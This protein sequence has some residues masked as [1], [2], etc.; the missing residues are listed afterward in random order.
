MVAIDAD[1]IVYQIGF[2]DTDERKF[3][4]VRKH[5]DDKIKEILTNTKAESYLG[6][7]SGGNSFRVKLTKEMT[8]SC[9]DNSRVI[10]KPLVK[11]YKISR[12]D[13]P[14]PFFFNEIRKYMVEEWG[15]H[16]VKEIEADDAMAMCAS[17][18]PNCI[19]SSKD[20]DMKQIATMHYHLVEKTFNR[21]DKD[22]AHYNLYR[23]VIMGDSGDDIAGVKGMGSD[24]ADKFLANIKPENYHTAV[25]SLFQTKYDDLFNNQGE[26]I[27]YITKALIE[28]V[29]EWPN[30]TLPK[31]TNFTHS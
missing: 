27:F 31:P 3:P 19:V 17:V 11:E 4:I 21:I 1:I 26:Q 15:F 30:F 22:Q 18:Y 8:Y 6:F 9:V 24:K 5:L 28:L 20:K 12:K 2:S 14:K 13:R 23:Q 10:Q 25:K 7:L 29:K 16:I